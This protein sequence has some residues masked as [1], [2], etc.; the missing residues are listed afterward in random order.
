MKKL[1]ALFLLGLL[2]ASSSFSYA[3]SEIIDGVVALVDSDV[4]LASELARRTN[5]IVEQIKK[6]GQTLP[7]LE[8][9]KKQVLDR[10]IIESLQLQTAKRVG[11]RISDA[12]LD[13]TIKKIAEDAKLSL[14]AFQNQVTESGTSWAIFREDVRNS[15]MISRVTGGMVSRRIK[16]SDKELDSVTAQM[17]QEG[18]SRMQYHL[19]HILLPISEGADPEVLN[20]VREQADQ[21]VKELRN[22]ASFEDAA[23]T[24][25]SGKNALEGG[26]LGW[27]TLSQLPTLFAD[28][29]KNMKSGDISEPLRS[30]S[31][32]HILKL[33][34]TKGGFAEHKVIQTDVRHI[35]ISPDAITDDTA[36]LEKIKLLRDRILAGEPFADLATVHS[37]DKGTAAL[38]GELG[39]SDPGAFVPEFEQTMNALGVNE[40]SEPVRSQFGWHIIEVL[41]RR[42]QDQTEDKKRERAYMILHNR[43]FE[44]ESEIWV[45]ELKE[46]AYIKLLE[47]K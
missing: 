1:K 11:V 45:R 21:L 7:D 15:A 14:D 39:W 40:L 33:K 35:L 26:D 6:R 19:G 28:M 32:L 12:E 16:I 18:L 3:K 44:E 30:G 47:L 38:G 4:V 23:V 5:S 24:Q 27:R 37:A 17:D 34:E 20:Q 2:T 13:A 43:K 46:Q 31:G 41:G 10:L 29:V 25:S 9:L 42:D 22:G 36:A 8:L